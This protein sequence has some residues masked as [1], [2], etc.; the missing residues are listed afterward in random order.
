MAVRPRAKEPASSQPSARPQLFEPTAPSAP[1]N[2]SGFASG[3][4][5][6]APALRVTGAEPARQACLHCL[7]WEFHDPEQRFYC[8]HA[9]SA[10]AFV[11]PRALARLT[12]PQGPTAVTFFMSC[13]ISRIVFSFP[14]WSWSTDDSKREACSTSSGWGLITSQLF[15]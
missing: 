10:R 8:C 13:R 12:Y 3:A 6:F 14:A 4:L 11:A 15:R 2:P 9:H 5:R 1:V 7:G